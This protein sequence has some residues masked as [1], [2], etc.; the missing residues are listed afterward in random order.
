M[1]KGLANLGSLMKQA[2]EMSSKMQELNAQLKTKR[3]TGSAAGGMVEVEVNGLGEVLKVTIEP[4]LIEKQDRELIE[5]L[6]PAA[7]N[8]AVVKAKQIHAEMMQELTGGMD[9]PGL[10]E[11]MG[12][13]G[14]DGPAAP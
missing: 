5:D 1:L 3:A 2:Q 12:K 11:A 14:G 10:S 7:V 9:L 8:A 6:I 13:L 4:S